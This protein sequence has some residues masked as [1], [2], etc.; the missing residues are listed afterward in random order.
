VPTCPQC[1][2]DPAYLARNSGLVGPLEGPDGTPTQFGEISTWG[3]VAGGHIEGASQFVEYMLSG[4]FERWLAI[5]PQGKY[6]LRFGPPADPERYVTAWARLP[7]GVERKAP[8]DRFYSRA[9]I[10]SLGA[11]VRSLQ[12]WGFE[13]GRAALV[14]VLRQD[15]PVANALAAEI[16]DGTPPEQAV[17][18]TQA[19]VERLRR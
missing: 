7:S 16:R 13:Q 6:P 12:R 5:S 2:K 4:G 11:G 14:G 8:L 18:E 3:I 9:S 1:R 15:E 10:D 19:A 17:R